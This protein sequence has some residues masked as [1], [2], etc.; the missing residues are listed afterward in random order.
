MPGDRCAPVVADH[1]RLALAE[2]MHEANDVADRVEDRVGGDVR[3]RC[4]L[5][6]TAHV[7]GHDVETG[8]RKRRDLVAP[9]VG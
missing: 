4:A 3:L 1:H 5:A 7:G 9:G 8:V 2:C 6:V